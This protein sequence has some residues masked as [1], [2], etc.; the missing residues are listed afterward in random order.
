MVKIL[1]DIYED[2]LKFHRMAIKYYNQGRELKFL[3]S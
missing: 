2:I 3:F 1:S